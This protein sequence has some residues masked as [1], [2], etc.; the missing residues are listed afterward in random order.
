MIASKIVDLLVKLSN[1]AITV[2]VR[3]R[4]RQVFVGSHS[5]IDGS[6]PIQGIDAYLYYFR[7]QFTYKTG[8]GL[9]DWI[10]CT[11]YIHNSGLKA[12]QRYRYST[13][14]PAHLFTRIRVLSLH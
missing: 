13:H 2:A 3:S 11:L 7:V 6:N 5:G 14:F 9:D 10:Y 8:F 4:A 12:I 1:E